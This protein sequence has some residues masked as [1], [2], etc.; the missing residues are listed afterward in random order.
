MTDL[1]FKIKD[2]VLHLFKDKLSK[3]YIYHN[4]N[5]TKRVVESASFL[6]EKEGISSEDK[7]ILLIA[8]WFHDTGYTESYENHE[9]QSIEIALDFLEK[10]TDFS[11]KNCKQ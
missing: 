6:A 3:N 8:V 5:H 7:E 10:Q 4:F 2:F 9:T 11:S 1:I